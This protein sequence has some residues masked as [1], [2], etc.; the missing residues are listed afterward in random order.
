MPFSAR[1]KA[2]VVLVWVVTRLASWPKVLRAAP[3]VS[4][5]SLPAALCPRIAVVLLL[6]LLRSSGARERLVGL[7][8]GLELLFGL[9]L[10]GTLV[11]IWMPLL[12]ELLVGGF[13]LLL[14]RTRREPEDSIWRHRANDAAAARELAA[15]APGRQPSKVPLRA[16]ESLR[17]GVV[18]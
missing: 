3:V 11:G 15:A 9:L 17:K 10:G 7:Q 18:F 13:D 6:L 4:A 12:G 2:H 8:D 1:T 5:A 16:Q 14:R